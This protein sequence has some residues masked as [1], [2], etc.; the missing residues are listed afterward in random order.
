MDTREAR[1]V[2]GPA[3]P[4]VREDTMPGKHSLKTRRAEPTTRRRAVE[5]VDAHTFTAHFRP[6]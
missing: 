5:V 1:A 4:V 2:A 3:F 6:R